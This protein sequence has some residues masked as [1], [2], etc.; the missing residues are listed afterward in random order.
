MSL[1]YEL[2]PGYGEA[3][4]DPERGPVPKT[5]NEE[6]LMALVKIL[7]PQI[8]VEIGVLYGESAAC[9]AWVL[10]PG[11]HLYAL[12]VDCER[13]RGFLRFCG[14]EDRV[15]LM[16]GPSGSTATQLPEGIGF[17]YIDGEHGYPFVSQDV[18]NLWPKMMPGG[19]MAFHDAN[20]PGVREFVRDQFPEA[21]RLP[22][23]HGLALVQKPYE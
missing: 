15:S 4:F 7:E 1:R 9:W 2:P 17:A 6:F 18:G 8:A 11:G 19:I 21:I 16:E 20:G 13:P 5:K 12:D 23:A 3:W 14:V 22:W 10:P